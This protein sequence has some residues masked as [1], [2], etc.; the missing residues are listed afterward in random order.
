MEVFLVYLWSIWDNFGLIKFIVFI[1]WV[2][3]T[4]TVIVITMYL[5][6]TSTE[7]PKAIELRSWAAKTFMVTSILIFLNSFVPNRNQMV[8]IVSAGALVSIAKNETVQKE[9][10]D[11]AQQVTSELKDAYSN[12]K[13]LSGNLVN[14]L[15]ASLKYLETSLKEHK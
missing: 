10:K 7:N 15:N 3:S 6:D 1:T 11:A 12:S 14:V 4:I 9:V 2:V 8:L 13:E 5:L